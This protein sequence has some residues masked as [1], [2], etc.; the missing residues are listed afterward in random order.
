MMELWTDRHTGGLI[1]GKCKSMY[2][3]SAAGSCFKLNGLYFRRACVQE[4][5]VPTGRSE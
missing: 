2:V 5:T 3:C 1:D 4:L